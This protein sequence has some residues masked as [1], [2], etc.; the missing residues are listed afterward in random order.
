[1]AKFQLQTKNGYILLEVISALQKEI[2]R[3][4]EFEAL[5][6]AFELL[7]NFERYFW[8]RLKVIINEDIGIANPTLIIL[9]QTLSEQYFEFRERGDLSAVLC[10]ANAILSACRSLK[11]RVGDNMVVVMMEKIA[12]GEIKLEIPDYALDKHTQR[13]RSMGRGFKHWVEEGS[14]IDRE[15]PNIDDPYKKEAQNY[16]INNFKPFPFKWGKLTKTKERKE[17]MLFDEEDRDE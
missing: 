9:V 8:R 7:P 10:V 3:G 14:Q 16:L 6:W 15:D 12:H 2:R 4:K 1:M 13:G 17:G 11:T 5:Y